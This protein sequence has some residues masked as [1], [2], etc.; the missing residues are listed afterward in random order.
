L[1]AS[2]TDSPTLNLAIG[3]DDEQVCPRRFKRAEKTLLVKLGE[4][5]GIEFTWHS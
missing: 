2:I 4:L 1:A 3:R 5:V